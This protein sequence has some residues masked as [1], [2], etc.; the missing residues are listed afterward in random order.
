MRDFVLK[1]LASKQGPVFADVHVD[2]AYNR[3][4]VSEYT[5]SAQASKTQ[6]SPG[7]HNLHKLLNA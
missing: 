5:H 7:Y 2:P 4:I 6:G 3:T 1:D